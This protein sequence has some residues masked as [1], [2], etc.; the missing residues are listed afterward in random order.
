MGPITFIRE[1]RVELASF[2]SLSFLECQLPSPSE[3]NQ[4]RNCSRLVKMTSRNEVP[5][6]AD[7]GNKVW[8]MLT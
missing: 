3:S 4:R 7:G 8:T 6:A 5:Y 2:V 1:K